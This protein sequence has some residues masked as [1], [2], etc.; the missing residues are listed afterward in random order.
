[1]FINHSYGS[2]AKRGFRKA[3]LKILDRT[4]DLAAN[5]TNGLRTL[6]FRTAALRRP[7]EMVK[8]SFVRRSQPFVRVFVTK[9]LTPK[10][11]YIHV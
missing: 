11:Q 7:Y 10:F 2:L 1:M 8:K 5:F 4:I 9:A 6:D 3:F